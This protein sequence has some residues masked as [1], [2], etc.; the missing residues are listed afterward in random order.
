MS[1]E[2]PAQGPLDPIDWIRR[3]HDR[4]LEICHQLENVAKSSEG[5]RVADWAAAVL[6]YLTEELPLHFEDE[7]VDLFPLLLSKPG[8]SQDLTAVLEQLVSEHDLDSGLIDPVIE[9]LR[10]I[11][12]GKAPRNKTRFQACVCTLT[13]ELRRHLNWQNRIVLPLADKKLTREDRVEL[14]RRTADRRGM[15]SKGSGLTRRPPPR[16]AEP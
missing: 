15:A 10:L 12:D 14:R 9:H 6:A 3:N 11:A 4:Q 7:E 16:R 2:P 1:T 5:D 8:R 13:A